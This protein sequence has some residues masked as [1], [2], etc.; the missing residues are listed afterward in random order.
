MWSGGQ[1]IDCHNKFATNHHHSS[2]AHAPL[3]L[4]IAYYSDLGLSTATPL[5]GFLFLNLNRERKK[6]PLEVERSDSDL[7]KLEF[8]L[9][10][11]FLF[12]LMYDLFII[13][14][15]VQKCFISCFIRVTDY[16]TRVCVL[17]LYIFY[18]DQIRY[19]TCETKQ[20]TL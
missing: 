10:L 3:S 6:K 1:K 5:A 14:H 17:Y 12:R 15:L 13:I 20:S 11:F 16:N 19:N 2:S 8:S 18:N 9:R 7:L 4:L